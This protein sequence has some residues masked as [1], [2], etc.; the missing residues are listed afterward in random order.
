MELVPL[1]V[2]LEVQIEI[3]PAQDVLDRPVAVQQPHPRLDI[4]RVLKDA[5]K[6][7]E[8]GSDTCVHQGSS[9]YVRLVRR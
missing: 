3:L 5:S 8:N 7:L 1:L 2:R 4:L 6:D 9:Q